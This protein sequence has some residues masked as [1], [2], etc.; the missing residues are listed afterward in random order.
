M[1]KSAFHHHVAGII[2]IRTVQ[3]VVYNCAFPLLVLGASGHRMTAGLTTWR[4]G[5]CVYTAFGFCLF[6]PYFS[7]A[8]AEM[9]QQ[10]YLLNCQHSDY[11]RRTCRSVLKDVVKTDSVAVAVDTSYEDFLEAL[12]AKSSKQ[13]ADIKEPMR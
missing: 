2:Q 11:R 13:I 9:H 12:Q 7:E 5:I 4:G 3:F 1:P 6:L 8:H 10:R